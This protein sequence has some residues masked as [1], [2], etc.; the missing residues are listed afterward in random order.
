MNNRDK[1]NKTK[2]IFPTVFFPFKKKNRIDIANNEIT[3][4][5]ITIN[6]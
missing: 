2:K 5:A 4:D 1:M 3:K 6:A